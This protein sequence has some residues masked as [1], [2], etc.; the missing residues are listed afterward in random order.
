MNLYEL[1]KE[2]EIKY[3]TEL[4]TLR[5]TNLCKKG[6]DISMY[7]G[8][9]TISGHII[10]NKV[11]VEVAGKEPELMDIQNHRQAINFLEFKNH[12]ASMTEAAVPDSMLEFIASQTVEDQ[13]PALENLSAQSAVDIV[14]LEQRLKDCITVLKREK[15]IPIIV[16]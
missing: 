13:K 5:F 12:I 6:Y 1:K 14:I 10:Y 3:P 7:E 2:L 15:K 16:E 11:Q 8:K 9:P 4:V